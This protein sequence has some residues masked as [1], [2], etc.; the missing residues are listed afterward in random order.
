MIY[1]HWQY[2]LRGNK[3]EL[4]ALCWWTFSAD[5]NFD[6]RRN[7]V[8][9]V[10][11]PV[12]RVMETFHIR[13]HNCWNYIKTNLTHSLTRLTQHYQPQLGFILFFPQVASFYGNWCEG[14]AETNTA[15]ILQRWAGNW[16]IRGRTPDTYQTARVK[17][18]GQ[19]RI[20]SVKTVRSDHSTL[21][22]HP[23]TDTPISLW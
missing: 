20:C 5:F 8:V 22:L 6:F 13:R 10:R 1:I 23:H 12:Q 2:C 21:L 11:E 9:K 19:V 18:S 16:P 3:K 14:F 17:T 15:Q 7:N 4:Q